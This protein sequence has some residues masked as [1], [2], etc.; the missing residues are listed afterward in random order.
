MERLLEAGAKDVF[1]PPVYMKKNRPAMLLT[2][3]AAPED[4]SKVTDIIFCETTTIGIRKRFAF[5]ICMERHI[6]MISTPYGDMRVKV[7]EYGDIHKETFE[8]EDVT[9]DNISIL[10]PENL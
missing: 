3:I 7:C 1:T 8:Y 6:R 10:F 2:V 5:L 4:E 9:P